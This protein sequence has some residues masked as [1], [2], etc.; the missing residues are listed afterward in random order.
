MFLTNDVFVAAVVVKE[1]EVLAV[2]SD[3]EEALEM[4]PPCPEDSQRVSVFHRLGTVF[5]LSLQS[6]G[7]SKISM[8]NGSP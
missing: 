1:E 2:D 5:V 7:I 6:L 3:G 8:Q 4:I